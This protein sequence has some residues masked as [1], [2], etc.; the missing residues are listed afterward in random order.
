MVFTGDVSLGSL[1]QVAVILLGGWIFVWELRTK[2][3]VFAAT[4]A[5]FVKRIDAMGED[6]SELKKAVTSV[7]VQ[8][9]R[10]NAIEHRLEEMHDQL[11]DVVMNVEA[12]VEIKRHRPK[13]RTS[14]AR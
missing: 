11:M 10:L 5:V 9:E 3:E 1:I 8:S 2:L 4:Y 6:I 12:P 13:A 14:R 7:A